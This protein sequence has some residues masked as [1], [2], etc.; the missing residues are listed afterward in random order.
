MQAV[1]FL[2]AGQLGDPSHQERSA[3]VG[4]GWE[5]AKPHKRDLPGK[6]EHHLG[7]EVVRLGP[8]RQ[9]FGKVGYRNVDSLGPVQSQGQIQAI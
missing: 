1:L 2:L 9:G 3:R 5:V 7:I 6:L 4:E 8:L